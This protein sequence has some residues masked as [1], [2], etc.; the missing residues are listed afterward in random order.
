MA[1]SV[2]L[3]K[4]YSASGSTLYSYPLYDLERL[5]EEARDVLGDTAVL[6]PEERRLYYIE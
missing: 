4:V 5:V 6:T 3:N 1:V 2:E